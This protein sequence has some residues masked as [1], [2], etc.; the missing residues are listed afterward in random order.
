M[1]CVPLGGALCALLLLL[2]GRRRAAL[3]VAVRYGLG[4]AAVWAVSALLARGGVAFAA[5]PFTAGAVGWLGLPGVGLV[6]MLQ[7]LFL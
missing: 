6:L 5:N 7:R 1:L 3:G 4:L 2:C